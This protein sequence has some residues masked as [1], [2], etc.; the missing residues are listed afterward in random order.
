MQLRSASRNRRPGPIQ[1]HATGPDGR[2]PM[3]VRPV[4]DKA[5]DTLV[6]RLRLMVLD[7][8]FD[9]PPS[10]PALIQKRRS[11]A[12]APLRR[13]R[14]GAIRSAGRDVWFIAGPVRSSVEVVAVLVGA[15]IRGRTSL[16]VMAGA[17]LLLAACGTAGGS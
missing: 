9:P 4:D 6:V 16:I 17:A 15:R 5:S 13:V 14:H 11:P 2:L 3:A 1:G 8:E 12:R 10:P 7:G